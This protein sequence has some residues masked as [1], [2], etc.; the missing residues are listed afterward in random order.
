V[1]SS[2]CGFGQPL[3]ALD[4][5]LGSDNFQPGS[6]GALVPNPPSTNT[7]FL[8]PEAY[9]AI[10]LIAD[11]DDCSAPPNTQLYSLNVGGS[12]Q[13]NIGNALGPIANYRCNEYG[14]LCKDPYSADPTDFIEPPL[15]PPADQQGTAAEPTLALTD[16]ESNDT[17][18]PL[19][20]PVQT[21]VDDIKMLKSDP[22]NQIVVA[23]ITAP[24]TPYTVAW[25]PEQNGQ[26][27]QAGELWP[28][29]LQSCGAKGD[30]SVNPDPTTQNTTDG[31][32]GSPAVRIAQFV[33][34]FP[35]SVLTSVCDSS[36][37]PAIQT[38][39]NKVGAMA[40]L[41]CLT[42][43]IQVTPQGL[44][45]CTVIGHL[46]DASQNRM[47][48]TYQNCA[49]SKNAA[50]CWSLESEATCTGQGLNLVEATPSQSVT[51]TCSVCTDPS[52]PGC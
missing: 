28:Q 30:P 40:G 38:I 42:G 35:N 49:T 4:H 5:A 8:R 2:G 21:F 51:V 20:T 45:D 34:A 10:I 25:M 14:H 6:T 26:N 50:P 17:Q 39:A 47:D 1:G 31:S 24:A 29:V 41:P 12:N 52:Q 11:K 7:G 43:Q 32:S 13:Q 3:A 18:S 48:V 19:T 37:Q 16:C 36:Y 33:N 46:V 9:L 27:T 22:D 23:A 44:P 15:N